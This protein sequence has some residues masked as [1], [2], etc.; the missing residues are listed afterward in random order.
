M[1]PF[2]WWIGLVPFLILSVGSA[3]GGLDI[4][5]PQYWTEPAG[6]DGVLRLYC[7]TEHL[8]RDARPRV[9]PLYECTFI[10]GSES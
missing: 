5:M 1:A 9:Q 8:V 10:E 4:Q 2:C 3:Y 7:T 6:G